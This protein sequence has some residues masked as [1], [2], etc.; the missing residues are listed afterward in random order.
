MLWQDMVRST[1]QD[2]KVLQVPAFVK[3]LGT[4]WA[5]E[6]DVGN[7]LT[8]SSAGDPKGADPQW[9]DED[10]RVRQYPERRVYL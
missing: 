3:Q 5:Q 10:I 6:V 2:C 1:L 4:A 8:V 9:W 7:G